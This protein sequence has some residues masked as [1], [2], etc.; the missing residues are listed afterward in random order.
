[1]FL[2]FFLLKSTLN[3]KALFESNSIYYKNGQPTGKS[4]FSFKKGGNTDTITHNGINYFVLKQKL[5]IDIVSA[6]K[7]PDT[8]RSYLINKQ[9]DK[10]LEIFCI[11]R[12]KNIVCQEIKSKFLFVKK[13]EDSFSITDLVFLS[14][15]FKYN[16]WQPTEC[17]TTE[18]PLSEMLYFLSIKRYNSIYN[19]RITEIDSVFKWNNNQRQFVNYQQFTIK[20][21]HILSCNGFYVNSFGSFVNDTTKIIN[22]VINRKKGKTIFQ[23]SNVLSKEK[24]YSVFINGTI[25]Y[26]KIIG[27]EFEG[28]IK[29]TKYEYP[30]KNECIIIVKVGNEIIEKTR[31]KIIYNL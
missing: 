30:N 10:M 23:S 4:N 31:Q 17:G 13:I 2:T 28:Y 18:P 27:T 9:E 21:N 16:S 20:D 26:E 19:S 6:D 1:M 11:T 24:V 8:L 15:L 3:A 5:R 22:G 29:E 12:E 25:Y 14:Q 7:T